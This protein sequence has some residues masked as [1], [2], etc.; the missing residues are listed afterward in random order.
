MVLNN[1][2]PSLYQ[3]QIYQRADQ[4]NLEIVLPQ[5]TSLV[6]LS[7]WISFHS[8]YSSPLYCFFQVYYLV[9]FH[10]QNSISRDILY[11]YCLNLEKQFCESAPHWTKWINQIIHLERLTPCSERYTGADTF[12]SNVK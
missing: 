2:L 11:F 9:V 7:K 4:G 1:D 12:Y 5:I 3:K 10:M 8:H 6:L